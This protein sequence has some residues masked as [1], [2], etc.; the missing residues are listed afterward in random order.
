[1][2]PKSMMRNSASLSLTSPNF[3]TPSIA[4]LT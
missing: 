3:L 2:P 4:T 1:M